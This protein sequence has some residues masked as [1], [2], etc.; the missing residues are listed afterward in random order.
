MSQKALPVA[1]LP[2]GNAVLWPSF[3]I[4]GLKTLGSPPTKLKGNVK[5]CQKLSDA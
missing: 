2:F 4:L 5:L 3:P 1:S